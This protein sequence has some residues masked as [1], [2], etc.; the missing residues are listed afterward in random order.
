MSSLP[1]V[2]STSEA[3]H[4]R[5]PI[6]TTLPNTSLPKAHRARGA[7][8]VRGAILQ[9]LQLATEFP[10]IGRQQTIAGVRKLVTRRYGYVIYYLLDEPA[11]E[12]VVLTIR[13]PARARPLTDR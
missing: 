3:R 2:A 11:D 4:A 8:R 6:F 1:S 5:Q 12:I 10:R 9:A 13:H 7:R